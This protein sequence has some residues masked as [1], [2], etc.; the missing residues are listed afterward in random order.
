MNDTVGRCMIIF[1][2][3]YNEKSAKNKNQN[4]FYYRLVK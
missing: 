2:E 4:N 1:I 3:D